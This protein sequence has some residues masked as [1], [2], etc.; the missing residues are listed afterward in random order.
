M[1][2]YAFVPRLFRY[3]FASLRVCVALAFRYAFVSLRV[4]FALFHLQRVMYVLKRVLSASQ[5]ALSI[6]K[7]VFSVSRSY[8]VRLPY[9]VSDQCWSRLRLRKTCTRYSDVVR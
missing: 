2:R 7:R 6:L 9:A 3:V 4:C 5:R 8:N 1:F